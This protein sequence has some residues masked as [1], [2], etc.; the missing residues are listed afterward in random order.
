MGDAVD[1]TDD[2]LGTVVAGGSLGAEQECRRGEVRQVS[3]LQL[4]VDGHDG[5]GIEQ[6]PLV[7]V[8]PLYLH[9]E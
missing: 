8:E 7:L 1:I 4:E 5:Q 3:R 6:L 2:R 9:I